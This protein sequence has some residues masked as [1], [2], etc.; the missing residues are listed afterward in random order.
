MSIDPFWIFLAYFHLLTILLTNYRF[1][2]FV[3]GLLR[4]PSTHSYSSNSTNIILHKGRQQTVLSLRSFT[5]CCHILGSSQESLCASSARS[6]ASTVSCSRS[7]SGRRKSKKQIILPHL[8]LCA[9]ACFRRRANRCSK[10]SFCISR[11]TYRYALNIYRE[12]KIYRPRRS[13][14]KTAGTQKFF[15]LP[16]CRGAPPQHPF[17]KN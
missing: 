9:S 1:I 13:Q 8:P 15:P 6:N 7:R 3:P 4:R 2:P 11:Q 16:P 10:H 14:L 12:Y 5:D 17:S